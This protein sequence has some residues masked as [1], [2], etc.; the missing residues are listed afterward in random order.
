MIVTIE[1]V[2]PGDSKFRVAAGPAGA[3]YPDFTEALHQ[4]AR[5]LKEYWPPERLKKVDP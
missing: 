2:T 5:L 1:R 3:I 4:V